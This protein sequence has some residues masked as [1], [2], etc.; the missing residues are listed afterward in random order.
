MLR[1]SSLLLCG[2]VDVIDSNVAGFSR[3]LGELAVA[4]LFL[5]W[6]RMLTPILYI[7]EDLAARE[8]ELV[9]AECTGT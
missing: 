7:A 4:F 6:L 2:D 1:V 9:V 5:C 3:C 8:N